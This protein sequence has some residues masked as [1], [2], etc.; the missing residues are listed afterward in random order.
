MGKPE[1]FE[2]ENTTQQKNSN[3][4]QEE[5]SSRAT[6]FYRDKENNVLGGVCSG[7]A[8]KF[9]IDAMWIRIAFLIAFLFFGTGLLLYIILWIIIP[10]ARTTSEKIE[11]RGDKVDINN[12]ERTIKDEANQLKGKM[13]E[14]GKEVRDSFTGDRMQNTK[15][16]VGDFIESGVETLKPVFRSI[17]KFFVFLILIGCLVVVVALGIQL[18][19]NWG[20]KFTDVELMGNHITEGGPQAW[21]LVTCAIALV[22]LP[23]LGI[24]FSSIKYLIGIKK[25]TKYVSA[26]LGILWTACLL[27]VIYLGIT[28]GRNFKFEADTSNKMSLVQPANNMLLVQLDSAVTNNEFWDHGRNYQWGIKK[29]GFDD[30]EFNMIHIEFEKSMDTNYAVIV[31]KTARGFDRQNAKENAAKFAFELNQSNDSIITIPSSIHLKEN[32]MFRDQEVHILIRVPLDKFIML[33]KNLDLYL[34]DNEYTG[35]LKD[36]DLYGN[37]LRMTNSGLKP[38]Y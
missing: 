32:E 17:A 24:I 30:M 5:R 14:F 7:F 16:N 22:V 8:A 2:S 10:V 1:E 11:M 20:E 26:S 36:I 23:L 6:K 27:A 38:A 18:M 37:K 31:N 19:T 28:I 35:D 15:K 25:K 34:D 29:D 12:I 4:Q 3:T 9:D 21:L 33:D 13:T